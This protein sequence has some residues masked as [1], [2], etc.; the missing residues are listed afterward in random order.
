MRTGM[1][2]VLAVV[3]VLALV[4][5]V[6]AWDLQELDFVGGTGKTWTN[7]LGG[8]VRID[9]IDMAGFPATVTNTMTII[10]KVPVAALGVATNSATRDF[11]ITNAKTFI[12][13]SNQI[14]SFLELDPGSMLRFTNSNSAKAATTNTVIMRVSPVIP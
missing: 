14:P 10:M 5:P 8:R 7:T 3:A 13:A 2:R 12:A 11:K 9:R 1:K 4:A 6:L